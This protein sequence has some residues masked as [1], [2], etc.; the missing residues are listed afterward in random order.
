[1]ILR[2]EDGL[3]AESGAKFGMKFNEDLDTHRRKLPADQN[4]ININ[5]EITFI[6]Y[7]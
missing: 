6:K 4:N 1:V 7:Q 5:E 3:A 2:E